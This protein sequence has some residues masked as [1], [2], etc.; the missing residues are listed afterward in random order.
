MLKKQIPVQRACLLILI[1]SGLNYVLMRIFNTTPSETLYV[2]NT[3]NLFGDPSSDKEAIHN[4]KSTPFQ[5]L[6][7]SFVYYQ[8]P[9]KAGGTSLLKLFDENGLCSP[10][11]RKPKL[12]C[13]TWG[14]AA[15]GMI[16]GKPFIEHK[17][18]ALEIDLQL[19]HNEWRP[20]YLIDFMEYGPSHWSDVLLVTMLRDP[21]ERVY[22]DLLHDGAW[23]CGGFKRL[24]NITNERK[25]EIMMNCTEQY[26]SK[27][28]SNMYTKI[29]SGSRSTQIKAESLDWH[30]V[31]YNPNHTVNEM[32][33][34]VAKQVLQQ[35]HVILILEMWEET[36]IQL[37]C[38]GI[39]NTN[40][41]HARKGTTRDRWRRGSNVTVS[42]FEKLTE[43]VVEL[44]Q[45]DIRLFQFARGLADD[46]TRE[47][48]EYL[49]KINDSTIDVFV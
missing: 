46:R 28:T 21:I 25:E 2:A 26:Q 15:P 3:P 7:W 8:H 22:S 19:I 6:N 47:C 18:R 40:L 13:L 23:S 10:V 29:F 48:R 20:F 27:F 41:E 5:P 34:E 9:R 30:G 24:P 42:D 43:M 12:K 31:P 17:Q 16:E 33:L 11:D 45:Y 38:Q 4:R 37:Q 35:F 44:N 36:K 32:H 14:M 49:S 39:N 1:V